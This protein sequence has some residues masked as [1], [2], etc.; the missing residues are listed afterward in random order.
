MFKQGQ[1][2]LVMRDWEDNNTEGK[3]GKIVDIWGSDYK[4]GFFEELK[5][6]NE[7]TKVYQEKY[8]SIKSTWWVRSY[9]I[10]TPVSK[11]NSNNLQKGIDFK[12][13]RCIMELSAGERREYGIY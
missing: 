1:L 2:V 5:K 3:L 8:G 12:K 6:T 10:K 13:L 11:I 4:I 7:D 9:L